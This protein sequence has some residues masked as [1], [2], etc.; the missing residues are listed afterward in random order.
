MAARILGVA[1]VGL[2]LGACGTHSS[3]APVVYGTD[4][5]YSA[6]IYNA[7][8]E[9]PVVRGASTPYQPQQRTAQAAPIRPVT[10]IY[11]AD[12]QPTALPVS[13]QTTLP[14]AIGERDH[15][16]QRGET[17]YALGRRY[18][19]HPNLIIS[20]NYLRAPYHLSVGQRVTI[21]A[22]GDTV[23]LPKTAVRDAQYIV[24]K[25]DTLYSISRSTG[26]A[27]STIAQSNNIVAPYAI[28]PGQRLFVPNARVAS[29]SAV[30]ARQ[31]PTHQANATRL[32]PAP[33]QASNVGD[34][35]RNVSYAPATNDGAMFTWPVKGKVIAPFGA[36]ELGRRN[37]GINIAAPIGTPV[38]ASADGEVVYRGSDLD[39]FGN[40]LL[41]K[42]QDGYVTAYAH[43]GSML[44][45]KGEY[46]RQGQVI[47][48]V[49]QSGSVS[50]PQ[51]HFEIR[52]KLKSVDPVALL[53]ES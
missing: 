3:S 26:V 9:A 15:I 23:A 11:L 24:R 42:H 29:A 36:T 28:S 35:A 43:N 41:V 1:L 10:A 22:V 49:G 30:Q 38:R 6:R 50:S 21:P 48:K 27:V 17:V 44:V 45:K 47:A 16:V 25:G 18:N 46:V 19:V 37:D 20:K 52:Q 53:D 4:P 34:I 2:T 39:G 14:K 40:L 31:S 12:E 51:L 33:S 8:N 13:Q 32:M 7:P 5:G